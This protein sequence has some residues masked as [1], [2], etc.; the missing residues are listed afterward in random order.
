MASINK[1]ANSIPLYTPTDEILKGLFDESIKV[2][3]QTADNG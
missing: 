1:N 3:H 2:Q